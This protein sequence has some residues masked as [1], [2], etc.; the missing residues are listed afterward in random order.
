MIQGLFKKIGNLVTIDEDKLKSYYKVIKEQ[1]TAFSFYTRTV[2]Y[3][4]LE[5]S[6][7]WFKFYVTTINTSVATAIG[8]YI[9]YPL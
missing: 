4:T 9:N 6:N 2:K 7:K 3:E 8:L 1:R 5:S